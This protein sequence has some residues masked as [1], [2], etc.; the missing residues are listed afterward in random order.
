MPEL[1]PRGRAEIQ[2]CVS[3]ELCV[4]FERI[5]RIKVDLL[6]I[7]AGPRLTVI[8]YRHRKR[9]P[10]LSITHCSVLQCCQH[11]HTSYETISGSGHCEI[12]KA[13]L[14]KADVSP[15]LRT[16][17]ELFR[18]VIAR[19]YIL[20]DFGR[21]HNLVFTPI[22]VKGYSE[23]KLLDHLLYYLFTLWKLSMLQ[24][25]WNVQISTDNILTY[26]NIFYKIC[27]YFCTFHAK[28]IVC[29]WPILSNVRVIFGDQ[30]NRLFLTKFGILCLETIFYF[31][32]RS[33]W[34]N[35]IHN[36]NCLKKPLLI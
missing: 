16:S 4:D 23:G 35:N 19:Y 12:S 3:A 32:I 27:K 13:L 11:Y 14:E 21:C 36:Y 2:R 24:F 22:F 8:S 20:Y 28:K 31:L 9:V 1:A 5:D 30:T 10:Y 29:P 33:L 17:A 25:L 18:P 26:A 7:D 6:D 15:D 34:P